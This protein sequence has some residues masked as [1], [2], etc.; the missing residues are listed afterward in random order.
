MGAARALFRRVAQMPGEVY[1][2]VSDGLSD[3]LDW[4]NVWEANGELEG[5]PG[6]ELSDQASHFTL[7]L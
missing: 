3:T 2:L 4:L 6:A 1:G 7:H 5:E